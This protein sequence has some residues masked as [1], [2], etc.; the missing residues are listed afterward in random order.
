MRWKGLL[1]GRGK[2][3]PI[4][5]KH[6]IV[7]AGGGERDGDLNGVTTSGFRTGRVDWCVTRY[8]RLAT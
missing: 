1:R 2:R 7:A 6:R 5:R 8:L 3:A 4:V